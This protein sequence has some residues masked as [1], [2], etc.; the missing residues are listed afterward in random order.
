MAQVFLL[1]VGSMPIPYHFVTATIWTIH[2]SCYHLNFHLSTKF[3]PQSTRTLP[4]LPL[5][6]LPGPDARPHQTS[7]PATAH[8]HAHQ[9]SHQTPTL[10]Y[11]A[12]GKSLG[13]LF[14]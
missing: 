7:L 4:C 13:T 2:C 14:Q 12:A 6:D 9:S 8:L 10:G 1:S 5:P 11:H 3:T